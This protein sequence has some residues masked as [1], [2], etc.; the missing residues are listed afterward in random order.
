MAS[1]LE[2]VA[3]VSALATY[4]RAVV[5]RVRGE[6]RRW[7]GEAEAI[8]SP[9]LRQ[10][11]L[12]ALRE[13]GQNAEA[14]AVFAI[15]APRSRRASALRA[16]TALQTAIDYLDTIGEQPSA[17]PLENGLAL[18]RALIEAVSPNAAPSDWYRLHPEDEDGGYLAT[19]VSA[20]QGELA[21]L[22]ATATVQATLQR[23]AQRCGEGQSHTHATSLEG[24]GRLEAWVEEAGSRPGYLWWEVAAGA[25]SSAAAHALIAA[26]ADERTDAEAAELV[27]AAYFPP[28][29]ALTVLLDDLVDL[30]QDAETGEHNYMT[31]YAS[32]DVA[33]GRLELIVNRGKAATAALRRRRRHAAI[34]AGVVGFY[35]SSPAARDDF[36][37]PIRVR[38]LESFGLSLRLVLAT[39]R[40]RRRG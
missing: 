10:A 17:R 25:S 16:M 33:A 11:A 22:P 39:M 5:P 31:Y 34:L 8:P 2:G 13:K 40:A 24:A 35:L 4:Q 29:G 6:L 1:T 23:A 38:L 32:G 20:C 36:A 26:A 9:A 30:T 14:T 21:A 37:A 18:H 15:L 19:L 27:D 7:E 12:A 3:M 28:I